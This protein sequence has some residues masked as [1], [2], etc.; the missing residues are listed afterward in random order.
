[1]TW[2]APP[3]GSGKPRRLI[4]YPV[5]FSRTNP[6]LRNV[7]PRLGQDTDAVLG[8]MG[9]NKETIASLRARKAV[10]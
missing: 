9:L 6:V 10:A 1:M 4:A 3:D 5:K 7:A 8:D 2:Q